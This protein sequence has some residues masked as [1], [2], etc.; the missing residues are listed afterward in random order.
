MLFIKQHIL[1]PLTRLTTT[2]VKIKWTGIE[3]NIF[4]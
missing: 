4:D 1:Q 2:N 3:Q